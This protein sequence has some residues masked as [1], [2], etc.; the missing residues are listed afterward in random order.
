MA[1]YSIEIKQSASKEI[2]KLPKGD[3][4]VVLTKIESLASNPRPHGCIKLSAQERY[5]I[6]C[7]QYRILYMIL[8][9]VLVVTIVKVAHRKDVY[10]S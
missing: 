4:K 9:H 5:R 10:R 6:R 3:L 2:E 7:G 8:D 1:R